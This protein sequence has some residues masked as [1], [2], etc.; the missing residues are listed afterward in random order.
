MAILKIDARMFAH[1]KVTRAGNAAV[2]VWTGLACW[3][4]RYQPGDWLIP[5]KLAR[6]FGSR[7]QLRRL[8]TSGLATWVGDDLLLDDELLDW[9]RSDVRAAIPAD[10]RARIY[11]RDGRRCLTCGATDDL[12]LDHIYPWSLGGPDTDDNLRT[13][14]RSCNSR[15]GARV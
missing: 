10:M 15:K 3:A 11:T 2:G 13:L 4:V 12:T 14:C 5:G 1:P 9:G 7:P 8:T 6:S